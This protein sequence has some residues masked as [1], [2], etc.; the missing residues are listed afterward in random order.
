MSLIEF[1]NV[2]FAY[3]KSAQAKTSASGQASAS[4]NNQAALQNINLNIEAGEFVCIL[5]ANGSGKSTLAQHINALLLPSEGEVYVDGMNTQEKSHLRKIRQK[6]GMIFQNPE[7]QAVASVVEDD[8]AFGPENLGLEPQVIH[9]RVADALETVHMSDKAKSEI[10]DLSGGEKQRVA[11]AGILAM[12]PDI[13]IM[14]EPNA[15]LDERGKR[16]IMR[17]AHELHNK[18]ITIVMITHNMDDATAADRVIVLS[19]GKIVF[20]GSPASVFCLENAAELR[21]I[22]LGMPRASELAMQLSEQGVSL[23]KLPLSTEELV[24]DIVKLINK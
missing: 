24:S 13:L 4:P 11:I 18:G 17:V 3:P 1:K 10:F 6:A 19:K 16:G 7:N 23:D 12:K 14:D 20:Q 15:M 5:G 22:N 21:R 8:V 9:E 2:T